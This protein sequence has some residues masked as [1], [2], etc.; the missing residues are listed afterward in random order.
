MNRL[1]HKF[2]SK[3]MQFFPTFVIHNGF[4]VPDFKSNCFSISKLISN[5]CYNFFFWFLAWL[6]WLN[7]NKV[8]TLGNQQFIPTFNPMFSFENLSTTCL[9]PTN[10][11]WHYKLGHFFLENVLIFYMNNFNTHCDVYHLAKVH[12]IA[13]LVTTELLFSFFTLYR[14]LR[15]LFKNIYS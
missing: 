10:H 9:I 15:T 6:I 5:I 1:L 7:L 12:C 14:H 2:F 4:Y 11:I 8:S 3:T 13:F